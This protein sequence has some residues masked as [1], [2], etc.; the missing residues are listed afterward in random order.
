MI[1]ADNAGD[2]VAF[3]DALLAIESIFGDLSGDPVF[4]RSDPSLSQARLTPSPR[5]S[6]LSEC[7]LTHSK[8]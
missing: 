5:F 3:I 6:A 7:V 8:G 1:T 2:P 4:D